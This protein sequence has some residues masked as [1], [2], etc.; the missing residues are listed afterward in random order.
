MTV[1]SGTF[2]HALDTKNRLFIPAKFREELGEKFFVMRN[3]DGCLDILTLEARDSISE[4]LSLLPRVQAGDLRRFLFSEASDC[5]PD[6]Q[7]RVILPAQLV[8]YAE[9]GK[10]VLIVGTD[11]HIELWNEEKYEEK[12]AAASKDYILALMNELKW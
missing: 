8:E 10:N 5:E 7:G 2:K 9:L 1:F 3:V 11:N 12:R 6:S 4:Q